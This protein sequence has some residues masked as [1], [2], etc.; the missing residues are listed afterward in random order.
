MWIEFG[1]F[2]NL[3]RTHLKQSPCAR[4]SP[5]GKGDTAGGSQKRQIKDVASER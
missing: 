5:V 1:D 2:H 3:G 4:D